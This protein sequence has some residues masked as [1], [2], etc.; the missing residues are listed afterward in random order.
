MLSKIIT[1]S[2]NGMEVE[3]VIVETDFSQGLPCLTLV[4][5]PDTTVRESKERIRSAII[6]SGYIFP[7]KR[8]TVNLSPADT[9]KSG[10]HFDLPM[11]V[12]VLKSMELFSVESSEKTAFLG[13]LSLDGII[14]PIESC[15]ALVLGLKEKGIKKIYLP[16]GNL[17][18]LMHIDGLTIYALSSFTELIDH[19]MGIKEVEEIFV[20]DI[21]IDESHCYEEKDYKDVAG[22]EEGK[23][24]MQICASGWHDIL[25]VGPPGSG[26]TMLASRINSIMSGPEKEEVL[27]IT[28]IHSIAGEPINEKNLITKRP[29]RKPHHT[30][31]STALIGGGRY[32]KPGE[33]SLAHRGILF[34]DEL[35]EFDRKTLDML[36]Q[37]LEDGYVNLTRLAAK[38]QYP[39]EFIMVAAMN[40]CPCGYYGDHTHECICNTAQRSRYIHKVS[41][42]LKDRIDLHIR[43]SPVD[44]K[45]EEDLFGHESISSSELKEGVI[46]AAE[47]QKIRYRDEEFNHNSRIPDNMLDKYCNF[48]KNGRAIL[49]MIS[50]KSDISARSL[51]K[52]KKVSRTIADLDGSDMICDNH[53]AEAIGYRIKERDDFLV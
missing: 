2:L 16:S 38:N 50:V 53:V 10:S 25:M 42:P 4:G 23:R 36:R 13:E 18:D 26:K 41:G 29:F 39:C 17:K 31:T 40:P 22:Q 43:I 6:N 3:K 21:Y 48:D 14:N 5:L 8:I 28:R 15:L 30:A 44:Y 37:P 35:P 12:G 1:A 19:L 9:R 46:M 49:K 7:L 47:I 20:P 45:I 27:E 51:A 34:L 32:S 52:I 24:A 11:A 33:L